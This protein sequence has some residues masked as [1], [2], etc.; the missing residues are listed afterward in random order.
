[1]VENIVA[2]EAIV[3]EIAASSPVGDRV[4]TIELEPAEDDEG[5]PFL[6]VVFQIAELDDVSDDELTGLMEQIEDRLENVDDRFPSVR[7]ADAA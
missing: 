3:R 6:R 2:L 5:R 1:M 7:F 4:R